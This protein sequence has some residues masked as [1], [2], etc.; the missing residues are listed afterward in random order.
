VVA[1]TTLPSYIKVSPS[2][3][4]FSAEAGHAYELVNVDEHACLGVLRGQIVAIDGYSPTLVPQQVYVAVQATGQGG[5]LGAEQ[6]DVDSAEHRR[7]VQEV[8]HRLLQDALG[9]V[10]NQMPVDDDSRATLIWGHLDLAH[11][12]GMMATHGAT[13]Q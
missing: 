4:S 13:H 5:E 11:E 10:G 1:S 3:V 9:E 8:C 12:Q 6:K 7:L 2:L